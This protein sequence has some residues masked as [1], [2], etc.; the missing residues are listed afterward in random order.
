GV[1]D[2]APLPAVDLGHHAREADALVAPGV[3]GAT[4][5]LDVHGD[6]PGLAL[7]GEVA[8]DLPLALAGPG[9]HPGAA[10][11][12]RGVV[13]DAEEVVGAHVGVAGLVLGVDAGGVDL[14]LQRGVLG[15]LGDGGHALGGREAAAH[16][17]HQVAGD[18][19]ERLVRRVDLPGADLGH[20]AAVDDAGSGGRADSLTH[21]AVLPC[22]GWLACPI[23]RGNAPPNLVVH[24]T[25]PEPEG[26]Q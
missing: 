1:P 23:D 19:L 13:L 10:E 26:F 16:L 14:D 21:A 12:D 15:P 11:A 7:D 25:I 8:V 5:E 24:T 3:D 4:E 17:G 6:R 18:E 2:Q 22:G 20:L 9:A